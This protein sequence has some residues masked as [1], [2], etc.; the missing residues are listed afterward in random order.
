L[1]TPVFKRETMPKIFGPLTKESP[2]ITLALNSK[3]AQMAVTAPVFNLT[4]GAPHLPP[5][6]DILSKFSGEVSDGTLYKY[7]DTAGQLD[8]RKVVASHLSAQLHVDVLPEKIVI[9]PGTK[10]ALSW[11]YQ[12]LAG[13]GGVAVIPTPAWVSHLAAPKLLG[14]EVVE[15]PTT[16]DTAFKVSPDALRNCLGKLDSSRLTVM[17]LNSPSNPTGAFYSA[18]ELKALAAVLREFPWVSV[19]EDGIYAGLCYFGVK[20]VSMLEVAPDLS[21]RLIWVGGTAKEFGQPGARIGFLFAPGKEKFQPNGLTLAEV[22]GALQGHVT[23]SAA[24]PMERL[25]RLTVS[26]GDQYS[27][28]LHQEYEKNIASILEAESSLSRYLVL[29]TKPKAGLFAY[30]ELT[31]EAQKKFPGAKDFC[32]FLMESAR[33]VLVPCE[34]FADPTGVRMSFAVKNETLA[35]A[36]KAMAETLSTLSD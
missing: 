9:T 6:E 25:A 35:G 15:L 31:S 18:E 21:E 36:L 23:G 19:L 27:K 5:S 30:F 11:G 29:K 12:T 28:Q 16:S 1:L 22:V 4:V 17:L 24:K 8:V 26:G 13:P 34:E 33:V 7:G 32:Q 14:I 10:S 3:A 20:Y 2:S